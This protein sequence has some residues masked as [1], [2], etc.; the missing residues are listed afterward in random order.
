MPIVVVKSPT[1]LFLK[2]G[3]AAQSRTLAPDGEGGI[4]EKEVMKIFFGIKQNL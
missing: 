2:G 1:P 4:S 3:A